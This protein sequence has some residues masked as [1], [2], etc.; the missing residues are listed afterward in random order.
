MTDRELIAALVKCIEELMPGIGHVVC[1]IGH[2]ND[3]LITANQRLRQEEE[4]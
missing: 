4:P 2:L 1:D 3:T